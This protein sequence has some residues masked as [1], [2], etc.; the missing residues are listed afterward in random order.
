MLK[1]LGDEDADEDAAP[2]DMNRREGT[3]KNLKAFVK[4]YIVNSKRSPRK[5]ATFN[6][7]KIQYLD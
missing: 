5:V 3:S 6:E 7:K 1:K 2:L 4:I